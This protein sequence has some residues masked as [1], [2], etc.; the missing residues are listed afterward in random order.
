MLPQNL[1]P[2]NGADGADA[3]LT[4]VTSL[5]LTEGGEPKQTSAKREIQNTRF[6]TATNHL[7]AGQ[8]SLGHAQAKSN[9]RKIY[10]NMIILSSFIQVSN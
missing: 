7:E 1:Q 3:T 10:R 5:E 2:G 4:A 6:S 8:K 9:V